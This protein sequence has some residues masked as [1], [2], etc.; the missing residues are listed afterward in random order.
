MACT[1]SSGLKQLLQLAPPNDTPENARYMR[2]VELWLRVR[3]RTAVLQDQLDD[4]QTQVAADLRIG[5]PDAYVAAAERADR[6]AVVALDVAQLK[7]L[8][9]DLYHR[10]MAWVA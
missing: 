6:L 4:L 2:T 5:L 8:A 9:D 10:V 1:E 7:V 3:E